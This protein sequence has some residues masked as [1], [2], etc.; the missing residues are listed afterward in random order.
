MPA[1]LVALY[2][3]PGI[4][5]DKPILLIGR[6]LECDI[7]IDSRKV[8]R[9]HCILA[10]I[11]DY[12]VVRDLGS[13]NGVRI[14]GVR[15]KEGRLQAGDELTIGSLRYQVSL[16]VKQR[17]EKELP[18][19]RGAKA[20]AKPDLIRDE[21]L[22]SCEEPVALPEPGRLLPHPAG[23]SKDIAAKQHGAPPV[24]AR[25][26]HHPELQSSV[27]IPEDPRLSPMHDLMPRPEVPPAP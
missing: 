15:V 23:R 17:N 19:L 5:V 18:A 27:I 14:N 11:A 22:E 20:T 9:R 16:D 12:L 3:G 4:L 2:A 13:T 25:P 26:H 10:Q 7:Q 21:D 24:G 8:S 1:Q 6:D